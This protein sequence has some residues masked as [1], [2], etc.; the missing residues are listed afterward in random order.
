MTPPREPL[1]D[2]SVVAAHL[3]MSRGWVYENAVRL[4]A[5]RLGYG[6]RARLRFDLAEVDERLT[7]CSA[8]RE[9]ALPEPVPQAALRPRRRGPLGRSV[10]LLP[11]RGRI[12]AATGLRE[13]S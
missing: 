7:A 12:P 10:E 8:S 3:G 5:R 6:P 11:I 4:G 13:V 1:V 9:S 2:A